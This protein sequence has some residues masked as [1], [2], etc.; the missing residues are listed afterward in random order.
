M[1]KRKLT[2][3]GKQTRIQLERACA[4]RKNYFK[5]VKNRPSK[6]RRKKKKKTKTATGQEVVKELGGAG[7]PRQRGRK[8]KTE[9]EDFRHDTLKRARKMTGSRDRRS[10]SI[11]T[12]KGVTNNANFFEETNQRTAF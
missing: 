5:S 1:K 3:E 8:E 6:G 12:S 10:R 2:R 4:Q 11:T 7:L 9:N